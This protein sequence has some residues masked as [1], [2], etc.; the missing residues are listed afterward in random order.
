MD[1][2][3]QIVLGAA[4]GEVVLGKKIG[5]RAMLWGA[6]GGTIP[7]LD[8]LGG[9]FLSEIDNLAFHRGFSHS[10][11]FCI[12][13]SFLFGWLVNEIYMSRYHKWIA[14]IAKSF[15]GI[16]IISAFQFLFTRLFPNNFI[17]LVIASLGVFLLT[18]RTIKK[19]YFESV[20]AM[21]NATTRDWQWLFFWAL[22]THPLLDCFTMYGTQLFLPFSDVRVAWST[23][24]VADPLYTVPFLICL[25]I[26]SRLS[27]Q[28]TKRRSWNYIG[29][30]LSSSYLLFTVVNKNLINRLFS[31]TIKKQ[32]IQIERYITNPSILTNIL[33]NYTGENDENYYLAQYSL[34]DKKEINFSKINK[35]HDLLNNDPKSKTIKILDWFSDGFYT[36]HK[37]EDEYQISDLRFGSFSG[38]GNGPNDFFFRFLVDEDNEGNYQLNEVQSGPPEDKRANLFTNLFERIIGIDSTEEHH[39][40][41]GIDTDSSSHNNRKLI[42]SDEFDIDGSVDTS[43]WF[44]Q[45][46][47]PSGGSWYNN[48]IQH[49]TDRM[50]NS[51]VENGLLKIVAKKETYTDQGYTKKYTSARLNSKFAFKYGRVD[52]RAKLPTGKGT[53]PAFWTLG[54]NI[55]ENGAYWYTKGFGT[56][57]WPACG[58][59]DIMEHWGKKQNLVK[60]A[61]HTPYSHGETINKGGRIISTCSSEFH[62]YSME[63]TEEK[64]VFMI[65]DVIHYTYQPKFKNT[66]NWPY[67]LE[68]YLLLNFAIEPIIAP[69]FTSDAIEIDYVRVYE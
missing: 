20:W 26:A 41:H 2:L 16:L 14:I 52:I 3:T 5:N 68:Q 58:E 24:S 15:A 22:I 67:T 45:T 19:R 64:L 10:I 66:D 39:I 29:I 59:I 63:W 23:I 4:V 11:L 36:V 28:S 27:H 31:D 30:V 34:F 61:T 18:Y 69:N 40:N 46:K 44:H 6:V 13:G 37:M 42:W 50:D 48:E 55:S 53:W 57:S 56:T 1:S 25:I 43:K 60:S 7:D 38:K 32:E 17:P 35:N 51:C 47:L 8:V 65:D 62:T 12:I 21:P 33:W 49:Y 54:K 9:L